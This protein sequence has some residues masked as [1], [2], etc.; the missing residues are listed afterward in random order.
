MPVDMSE[1]LSLSLRNV[2]QNY[3]Q[4]QK[5]LKGKTK[6]NTSEIVCGN[7]GT[8]SYN[9]PRVFMWGHDVGRFIYLYYLLRTQQST[10]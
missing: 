4:T 1:L 7:A 2:V 10:V 3:I 9:N 8:D 5:S 6:K